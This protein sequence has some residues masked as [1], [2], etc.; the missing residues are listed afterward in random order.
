MLCIVCIACVCVLCRDT[1]AAFTPQSPSAG[2]P[3]NSTD[4][5]DQLLVAGGNGEGTLW[6]PGRPDKIGGRTHVPVA[7]VR[8]KLI[9]EGQEDYEYLLRH[10]LVYTPQDVGTGLVAPFLTGRKFGSRRVSKPF[11]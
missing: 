9:R 4:A 8:L 7:S 2:Q 5:W 1:V 10:T 6:Y 3:G 11:L